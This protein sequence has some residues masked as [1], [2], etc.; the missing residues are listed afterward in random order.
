MKEAIAIAVC[1]REQRR[2]LRESTAREECLCVYVSSVNRKIRNAKKRGSKAQQHSIIIAGAK[3]SQ[4]ASV[5]DAR[6]SSKE[7]WME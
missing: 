6:G 1:E 7:F 4:R 3:K 5:L 2:L